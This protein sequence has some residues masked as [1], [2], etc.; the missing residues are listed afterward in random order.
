MG[1]CRNLS[2]NSLFVKGLVGETTTDILWSV[3]V[4]Q[5]HATFD[6]TV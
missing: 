4:V 6:I 2:L 3:H 1:L 5:Y